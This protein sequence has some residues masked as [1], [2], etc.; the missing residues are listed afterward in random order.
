MTI[1]QE[2]AFG[3]ERPNVSRRR[4]L[5]TLAT[6]LEDNGEDNGVN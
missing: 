4:L 1:E 6:V 2:L 3:L 5:A